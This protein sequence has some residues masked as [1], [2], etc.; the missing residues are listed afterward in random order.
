[1]LANGW[2]KRKGWRAVNP[3]FPGDEPETVYT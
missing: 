3:K 2:R 1:M